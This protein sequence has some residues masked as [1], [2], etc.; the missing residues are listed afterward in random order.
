MGNMSFTELVI[1][2]ILF[3]VIV[4]SIIRGFKTLFK[5]KS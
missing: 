1:V 4:F 3:L 2:S 5:R